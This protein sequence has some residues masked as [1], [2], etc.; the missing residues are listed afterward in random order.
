[1]AEGAFKI[2]EQFEQAVADYTG[3][4]YAVA[5]DS[6][7]SAMEACL[8]MDKVTGQT[9]RIPS[10]TYMSVPS[11]VIL[12]GNKVEFIP[13]ES[14]TITG[15]YLLGGTRIWDSALRFTANMYHQSNAF[16][17]NPLICLSFSGPFKHLKLGKGGMVL[18]GNIEEAKWLKKYRFNGRNECSYHED[19]FDMV[20]RNCYM[21]PEIAAKGLRD[22][23][24]FYNQD[25]TKK[26]NPDITLPYPDL[27]KFPIYGQS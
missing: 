8:I 27:S 21:L 14:E 7:S 24:Q 10:R 11:C 12:T 26:H 13:G 4:P 9:I 25:G 16:Y 5:F 6:Q 18:C 1:M 2:T 17:D 22:M 20:G 19:H 15:Y 23:A 3:A